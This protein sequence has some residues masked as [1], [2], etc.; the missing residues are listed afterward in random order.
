M[1]SRGD[2]LRGAI[3]GAVAG[4]AG[5]FS[6]ARAAGAADLIPVTVGVVSASS[7]APFF[8]AQKLGYY[9]EAGLAVTTVPFDG[10]PQ[11]IVPLGAGQLD[12]GSGGPSAGLYNAIAQK[13]EIKM[14]ADKARP[15]PGNGYGPLMVRADLV[16]SG[17]YKSPRDLKGM[18]FAE[19]GTGSTGSACI[20][21]L[22]ESVNLTLSD[23]Q[24]VKIGYRD[25]IIAFSNGSIDASILLEPNATIAERQGFVVRVMGNDK[26]YPNQEQ[27]VVMYGSGF[28]HA[29][30]DVGTRFMVAYLRAARFYNSALVAGRLRGHT[31]KAVIDI[32][33]STTAVKD[34]SILGDMISQAV[35]VDGKLNVSSLAS[36][37]AFYTRD[38]LIKT[39]VTIDQ[40]IDT[41][42]ARDAVKQL[43]PYKPA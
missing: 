39:P 30:R 29:R 35:D 33:V 18:K 13:I 15:A 40:A 14:V 17:A 1:I 3:A 24:V 41:A 10:A 2:V 27:A 8:L 11:M 6:G 26:W 38:G 34:R 37:L 5:L 22:L 21:R 23:L 4:S 7:D 9:T 43:G 42:F 32:L 28:L 12:V 31:S 16:K 19:A 20:A 36:D 25:Q